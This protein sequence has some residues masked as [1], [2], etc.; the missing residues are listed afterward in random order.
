MANNATQNPP[1]P[2]GPQAVLVDKANIQE[3]IVI[4]TLNKVTFTFKGFDF[5]REKF[6]YKYID[7][8]TQNE[9]VEIMGL[10]LKEVTEPKPNI[11]YQVGTYEFTQ[12]W[13]N[14]FYNTSFNGN[15][16]TF[17]IE[18]FHLDAQFL[19]VVDNT[20][21]IACKDSPIITPIQG[22]L[23]LP[24]SNPFAEIGI[25]GAVPQETPEGSDELS[26]KSGYTEP[27]QRPTNRDGK[28]I[29]MGQYNQIL[30]DITKSALI[31]Q[32]NLSILAGYINGEVDIKI[33]E[34]KDK[35]QETLNTPP[36][37]VV[38]LTGNQNVAGLKNFTGINVNNFKRTNAAVANLEWCNG[39]PLKSYY[40]NSDLTMNTNYTCTRK[41][42]CGNFVTGQFSL[43]VYGE[44]YINN[45]V[46]AALKYFAETSNNAALFMSNKDVFSIKKTS[47]TRNVQYGY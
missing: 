8:N 10:T 6:R 14:N 24:F 31:L 13:L 40:A 16:A 20:I 19:Q 26:W 46:F 34:I 22:L 44:V 3:A 1:Q 47:L 29:K 7:N 21:T 25:R 15:S 11:T 32:D 43:N 5:T 4:S 12:N 27:Y 39:M 33:D 45:R 37:N 35:L 17:Q 36:K 18:I 2:Q 41:N 38:F 9:V 42:I 28:W 30:H 23:P